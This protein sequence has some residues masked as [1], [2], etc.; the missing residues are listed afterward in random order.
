M[1]ELWKIC[2]F[3][4]TIRQIRY[5]IFY[6]GLVAIFVTCDVVEHRGK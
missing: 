2:D 4:L 3:M 6:S 5:I 1:P